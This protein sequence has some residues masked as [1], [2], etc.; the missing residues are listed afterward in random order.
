MFLIVVLEKTLE[1]PLDCKEIK[2]V[3]LKGIPL[4]KYLASKSQPS[5]LSPNQVPQPQ[6]LAKKRTFMP[7]FLKLSVL[8]DH[9][10]FS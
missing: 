7:V 10:S 5:Y 9:F 4:Q 6:L 3:N 2:P 8:K 1:R